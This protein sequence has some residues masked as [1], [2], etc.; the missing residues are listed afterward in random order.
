MQRLVSD[1]GGTNARFALVDEAGSLEGERTLQTRDFPG[2][3][4]AA[5][6]YLDGRKVDGVVLVVAGPVESDRIALTNCP[7]AFSL[8][9]TRLALGVEHLVAM[10]DFVAQALSIPSL[11][12]EDC[13]KLGG[14]G[15]LDD[16]PIAVIGPGTGLG[17]AGL[18]KLAGRFHPIASEGGHVAFAPRDQVEADILAILR[19]RYGHVSN[20]RLLSGPGLVNLAMALAKIGGNDL[21]VAEPADVVARAEREACPICVE[22][23]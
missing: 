21:T 10:N 2:V 3:V 4:D 23:I 17:V 19:E 18:L 1:I 13:I 5:T 16:R 12:A 20:E 15:A 8:K 22:A 9:E 11:A 6:A 14:G 7:W